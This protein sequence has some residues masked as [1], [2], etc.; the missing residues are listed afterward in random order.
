M[1]PSLILY[2]KIYSLSLKKSIH[3]KDREWKKFLYPYLKKKNVISSESRYRF[4]V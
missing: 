2:Q 4:D 3:L 1:N